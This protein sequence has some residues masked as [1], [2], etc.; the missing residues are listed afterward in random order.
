MLECVEVC[1]S[2]VQ[3][4]AVWLRALQCAAECCGV[5]RCDAV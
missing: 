3:C 1:W 5:L 2:V 4:G